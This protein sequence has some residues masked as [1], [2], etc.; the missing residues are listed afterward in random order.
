MSYTCRMSEHRRPDSPFPLLRLLLLVRSSPREI[1][2]NGLRL[3]NLMKE[4]PQSRVDPLQ[5][6]RTIESNEATVNDF[7]SSAASDE[8]YD[9]LSWLCRV[10][11]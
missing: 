8:V 1:L 2:F 3:S 11:Y 5:Y 7:E 10:W 9:P 6:S 4:M